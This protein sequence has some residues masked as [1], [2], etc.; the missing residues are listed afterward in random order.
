MAAIA[1]SFGVIAI[2]VS[3]EGEKGDFDQNFVS[4]LNVEVFQKTQKYF[5]NSQQL[6]FTNHT[7]NGSHS[8][9]SFEEI[10]KS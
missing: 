8:N 4:K 7:K 10:G 1:T 5:L 6:K 3:K 2:I 9:H